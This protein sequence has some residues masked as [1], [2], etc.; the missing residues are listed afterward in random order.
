MRLPDADA[1][2]AHVD[3]LGEYRADFAIHST[4]DDAED[5]KDQ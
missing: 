2:K 1:L 5:G 3:G 4:K